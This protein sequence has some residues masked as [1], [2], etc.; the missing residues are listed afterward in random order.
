MAATSVQLDPGFAF[1]GYAGLRA[2]S[3]HCE[4]WNTVLA[5]ASAPIEAQLGGIPSGSGNKGGTP[6]M[7]EHDVGTLD[8]PDASISFAP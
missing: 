2:S 6:F 5:G 4:L 1:I 3:Q 7:G 8:D